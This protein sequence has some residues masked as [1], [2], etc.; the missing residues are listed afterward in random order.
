MFK[1]ISVLFFQICSYLFSVFACYKVLLPILENIV[2]RNETL[3]MPYISLSKSI[4]SWSIWQIFTS[5]D[6]FY[7]LLSFLHVITQRYLPELLKIHPVECYSKYTVWLLFISVYVLL[8]VLAKNFFKYLSKCSE[9]NEKNTPPPHK[10]LPQIVSILLLFLVLFFLYE[11]RLTWIL[12]HD[13]WMYAYILL[14]AIALILLCKFEK[15]YVLEEK[16][17]KK[18]IILFCLLLFINAFSNE[19][20]RFIIC[21]GLFIGFLFHI[22]LV[23]TE[24]NKFKFF[25]IYFGI[26]ILN[27]LTFFTSNFQNWFSE[28]DNHYTMTDIINIFPDFV[29][30]YFD[31]VFVE[32][33]WLFFFIALFLTVIFMFVQDRNK[34]KRVLIYTISVILSALFFQILLIVGCE[35]SYNITYS[36]QHFGIEFIFNIILFCLNISLLGYIFSYCKPVA[37]KIIL[38]IVSLLPIYFCYNKDILNFKYYEETSVNLRRALYI[39]DRIYI[40]ISDK[41]SIFYMYKKNS[42]ISHPSMLYFYK[43][44]Y[45]GTEKDLQIGFICN[46]DDD[47]ETC[48][49]IMKDFVKQKTGYE[50]TK[51]ELE[52]TDFSVY[53]KYRRY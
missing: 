33:R 2:P 16:L 48:E 20:F 52:K 37:V 31:A 9:N 29:S 12:Q 23:K 43:N 32:N 14:P 46:D 10:I 27:C 45:N 36:F 7:V 53:D 21:G 41:E 47:Y 24:I 5:N 4:P 39:L 28:R 51:E 8:L 6:H 38:L 22:L 13:C 1:G 30:S 17:S 42:I 50:F 19:F 49:N 15:Y 18:Q 34:N 44:L 40:T 11:C 26:A 35:N 25:G 3:F